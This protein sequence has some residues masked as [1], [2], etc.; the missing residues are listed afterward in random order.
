L[1]GIRDVRGVKAEGGEMKIYKM[2]GAIAG[3]K[4]KNKK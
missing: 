1:E 4:D 3:W 2:K